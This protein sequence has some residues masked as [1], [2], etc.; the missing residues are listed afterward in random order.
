[1]M[2]VVEKPKET[3]MGRVIVKAKLTNYDDMVRS[4]AGGVPPEQIRSVEKDALVDTGATLL[5]LPADVAQQLG[6]SII[7]QV[8]V[9]YAD[10]R[11]ES[12]GMA[13]GVVIE[14]IGR[15]ALVDAVVEAPGAKLL[16]GQV[17]LEVMDLIVDPK[18]GTVGP[19]PESPDTPLIEIY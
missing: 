9:T 17:P 10:G 4:Q 16:I 8:N 13:R 15:D 5:V 14:I 7:R 19:R 6:L 2:E 1:M 3:E 18:T 11:K 12:R